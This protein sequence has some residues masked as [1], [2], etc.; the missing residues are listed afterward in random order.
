MIL[1]GLL[2][3]SLFAS[4]TTRSDYLQYIA[5][6]PALVETVGCAAEG[7]IEIIL[8]PEKMAAIEKKLGRDVGIVHRDRYWIWV[9]DACKF[10][11]GYEGIYARMMVTKGKGDSK[12]TGV[13][14]VP[15]LPNG[16][17]VLVCN[18]RHATRSW[19]IELPR[20]GIE[21]GET[22]ENAARREALEETGMGLVSLRLLGEM[23]PDSG[24]NGT[25]IPIYEARVES[26]QATKQEKTEAIEEILA[27]TLD[28]IELAF[29]RG[30]HE[31]S[32]GKVPVRDS[33]L[34]YAVLLKKAQK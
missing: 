4:E 31:C 17:I 32:K 21:P 6:N 10:P 1:L 9:N 18:Y 22:A 19:E 25:T 28:E 24:I 23:N 2:F 5:E 33:F 7:E 12:K 15:V 27:L 13:A 26:K 20:G 34:A 30:Y 29:V 16:K 3:S 14:V 11:S 8:D